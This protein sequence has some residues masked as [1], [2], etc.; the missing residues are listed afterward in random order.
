[1][2]EAEIH[3]ISWHIVGLSNKKDNVPDKEIAQIPQNSCDKPHTQKRNHDSI[4]TPEKLKTTISKVM[5]PPHKIIRGPNSVASIDS[6]GSNNNS[7]ESNFSIV[8]K[9]NDQQ[10]EELFSGINS[11][12]AKILHKTFQNIANDDSRISIG[13]LVSNRT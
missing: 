8:P 2:L 7:Q 4:M 5:S 3:D 11:V 9:S 13:A 6:Q 10:N 1:M 12:L